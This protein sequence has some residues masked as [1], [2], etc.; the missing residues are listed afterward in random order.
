MCIRD[1]VRIFRSVSGSPK[2]SVFASSIVGMIAWWS[3]TF[4]LFKSRDT[5]GVRATSSIKAVSYTHLDVYKRQAIV[6]LGT[7][8]TV[9]NSAGYELAGYF[10]KLFAAEERSKL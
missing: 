7:G 8:K 9:T 10:S 4:L 1:R 6:D 3:D 2:R 5:S